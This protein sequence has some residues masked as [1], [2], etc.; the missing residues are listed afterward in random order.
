[1]TVTTP[2]WFDA[3]RNE[4]DAAL[5]A[6]RL[7]HGLLIHEDPGAGLRAAGELQAS[8]HRVI[9]A[10]IGGDDDTDEEDEA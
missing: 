5:R 1:M 9:E 10:Y 3:A 4:I 6:N 7:S 8:D 2:A